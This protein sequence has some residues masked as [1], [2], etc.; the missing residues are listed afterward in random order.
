LTTYT[1]EVVVEDREFI[2][3]PERVIDLFPEYPDL[4]SFGAVS[5]M[6]VPLFDTDAAILGR[7]G[8]H[9]DRVDLHGAGGQHRPAGPARPRRLRP[10]GY[11]QIRIKMD[12][13]ADC[14]DEELD[15]LLA[16]AEDHSPVCNTVCRPVPVTVERVRASG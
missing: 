4:R 6:G 7:R 16:F 8:G 14:S 15:A 11:E 10:V 13:R 9:P 2:H 3:V 5:Y 1:C 12:I